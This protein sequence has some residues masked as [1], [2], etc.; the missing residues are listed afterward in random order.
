MPNFSATIPAVDQNLAGYWTEQ[1]Q[2]QYNKLPY[3]LELAATERRKRFSVWPNLITETVKWKP[4]MADTMKMVITEESPLLR[5]EARP[6]SIAV[7]PKTDIANVRERTVTASLAWQRFVSPHMRFLPSYQDFVKEQLVPT[8]KSVEKDRDWFEEVFYRTY[9]WDYSPRVFVAGYGLVDV[10][11]GRS[12]TTSLKTAA[13]LQ[14]LAQLCPNDGYLT[15]QHLFDIVNEAEQVIGM[16]PYSGSNLPLGADQGMDDKYCLVQSHE[17]FRQFVND[18]W[19]KENRVL[20]N[21]IVNKPYKG[22]AMGSLA[23]RLERL[24]IRWSQDSAGAITL[25]SP[26]VVTADNNQ[27]E[28]NRTKPNPLFSLPK[29]SPFEIAWLVGGSHYKRIETGAPPEFFSGG[30]SDPQKLAGMNWNGMIYANKNFIVY[31]KDD[32]G[33]I[34][35]S[36]N[37]FGHY[38]RW[39]GELSCGMI[40]PNAFN[41]LPILYRRRTGLTNVLPS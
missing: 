12:G 23:H 24:P 41:V 5:Q 38:M 33:N 34:V 27:G 10:P 2:D 13:V 6:N 3:Y 19:V 4:N 35:S 20:T 16:T 21:D 17:S 1:D 40:G 9:M 30:T 7:A 37:E 29:N 14:A 39:Q 15:Y 18:P 25:P 32:A 36:I 22:A 31:E 11:T 28:L 8:R 26:E